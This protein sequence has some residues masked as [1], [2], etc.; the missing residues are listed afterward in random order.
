[1][2]TKLR[3]GLLGL[4]GAVAGFGLQGCFTAQPPP[5]CS[6]TVTAAGLGLVPYYTELKKIDSTGG[7]T[8]GDLDHMYV[9]MQRFRTKASGGD[10]T[11]ALKPSFLAD[12]ALGY[13]YSADWDVYNNCVNEESCHGEDDPELTCVNE[14]TD[15]GYEIYDGTPAVLTDFP[16]GGSGYVVDNDYEVDPA[17]LCMSVEEALPRTDPTD[18]KGANLNII[19][20]MP[21]FPTNGRCALTQ[22]SGGT[23]NFQEEMTLTGTTIPAITY[24]V[25]FIETSVINS[26]TIPGIAF[27]GKIRVTEGACVANYN[28]VGFWSGYNTGTPEIAC[29]PDAGAPAGTLTYATEC[30]PDSDIDAGRLLGSGMS[31]AFKPLCN[32]DTEICVPSIDLT[33][34]K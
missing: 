8:C 15:G 17:N 1:M 18:T 5:E 34:A 27:T 11:V 7:G 6:V 29:T 25:E 22:K 16:D 26:T 30:D 31:P 4:V 14:L 10:F 3:T 13:V 9:G 20:D 23:E 19:A 28:A 24:K 2:N 12:P 33:T 21:Q 32:V